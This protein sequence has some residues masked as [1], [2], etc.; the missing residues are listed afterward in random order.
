M[1]DIVVMGSNTVDAFVT[2]EAEIIRIEYPSTKNGGGK[3]TIL[4]YPLH[5]K[6]LASDVSFSVGGSGV[7][8]A[9]AFSKIGLDTA[10]VGCIGED[11]NGTKIY[12]H[13]KERDI[14]FKGS[15]G[16]QSGFSVILES[17]QQDRTI[18]VNKGCN[19]DLSFD[20]V[21]LDKLQTKWFYSSTLLGESY[22]TLVEV[23]KEYQEQGVHTAVNI[24]SY[25]ARKGKEELEPLLQNTDALLINKEEGELLT[26]H[27]D[28]KKML[29]VLGDTVLQH[30]VIT[31][32]PRGVYCYSHGTKYFVTA[33]KIDVVGTTGAGDAFNT[34]FIVALMN[35]KPI[36]T[37]LKAG[38]I[39]AES[40]IQHVNATD[41]LLTKPDLLQKTRKDKRKPKVIQ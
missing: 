12:H 9:T 3:E 11:M 29:E 20:E 38:M 28:T 22:E 2:T 23:I 5:D 6:V 34:G 19:N 27:T 40:T 36:E 37:A 31:D 18:L 24:S 16:D 15:L 13:L 39:Q 33:K 35:D 26:S 14:A 17:Q 41:G 30:V 21:N 4:G 1:H 8:A 32:G 10:Y 25:L 7:N